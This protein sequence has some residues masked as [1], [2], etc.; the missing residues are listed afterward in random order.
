MCRRLFEQ[1]RPTYVIHLAARVGGLFANMADQVK[2]DILIKHLFIQ[3][4]VF[5]VVVD[6]ITAIDVRRDDF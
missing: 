5:S 4:I 2:R 3:S 1:H 6:T